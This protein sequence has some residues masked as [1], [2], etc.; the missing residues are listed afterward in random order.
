[1]TC[2]GRHG[3]DQV[4]AGVK[5]TVDTDGKKGSKTASVTAT[6]GHPFWVPELGEWL[7]ATGLKAG[8]CLRTHAGSRVPLASVKRWTTG[9]ATVHNFTVFSCTTWEGE[10][11]GS[12]LT[13]MPKVL[14][15]RSCVTVER[16]RSR[17]MQSGLRSPT[18]G[19][20]L[21]SNS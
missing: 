11:L 13:T 19:I 9:L 21:L 8:E 1:V 4:G 6:D 12:V 7:D 3:A 20:Q 18:R 5:V 14:I 10:S 16:G 15:L 2:R 17:N